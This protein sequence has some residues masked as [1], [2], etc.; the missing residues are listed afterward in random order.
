MSKTDQTLANPAIIRHNQ[1]QNHE[2]VIPAK[3]GI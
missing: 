1:T 3:A 2:A